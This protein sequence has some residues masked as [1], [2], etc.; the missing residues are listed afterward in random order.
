MKRFV[1]L[2]VVCLGV[3]FVGSL[4]AVLSY[5]Q[6]ADT[7]RVETA[8]PIA[9]WTSEEEPGAPQ[10]RL[11]GYVSGYCHATF[12][13]GGVTAWVD[14]LL[15]LEPIRGTGI[16]RQLMDAFEQWA[17]DRESVSSS[18]S[19]VFTSGL[20]LEGRLLQE[21][22]SDWLSGV[23]PACRWRRV[24]RNQGKRYI[25]CSRQVAADR[26]AIGRANGK[27]PPRGLPESSRKYQRSSDQTI[28]SSRMQQFPRPGSVSPC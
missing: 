26:S 23:M 1:L 21:V 10:R 16:G 12:Y 8:Q 6:F 27:R 7:D 15:V 24:I 13:A 4:S 11:V 19:P 17:K 20:H 28:S 5:R 2:A 18:H 9:C 14:E 22:P 25:T 3:V